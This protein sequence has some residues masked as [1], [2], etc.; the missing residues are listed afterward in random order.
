MG[1]RSKRTTAHLVPAW[2]TEQDSVSL[3]QK[4]KK[5]HMWGCL[6]GGDVYIIYEPHDITFG[7]MKKPYQYRMTLHVSISFQ[8]VCYTLVPFKI[9]FWSTQNV[10]FSLNGQ[11]TSCL[12]TVYIRY[13]SYMTLL[14]F[15]I[16]LYSDSIHSATQQSSAL[17]FQV[18]ELQAWQCA[19]L[20][21]TSF[22]KYHFVYYK[23]FLENYI[24]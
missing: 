20:S 23:A 13:I 7:A 22:Y 18:L 16:L 3:S 17:S 5:A 10:Y 4:K 19:Q 8:R 12:G 15:L 6:A 21:N 9:Q 24:F 14:L 2:S 11:N 1:C